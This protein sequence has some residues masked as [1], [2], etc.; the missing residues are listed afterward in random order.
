MSQV[1]L[2]TGSSRGLGRE[3][4]KAALERS[5]R[6]LATARRPEALDVLVAQNGDRLRTIAHDVTVPA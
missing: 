2:I 5:D 3:I 4:V 1:W 6:V